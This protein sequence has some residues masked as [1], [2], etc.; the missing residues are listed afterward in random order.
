MPNNEENKYTVDDILREYDNA[1]EP[2]AE[3]TVLPEEDVIVYKPIELFE[4]NVNIE[5]IKEDIEEISESDE[6]I[7]EILEDEADDEIDISEEIL[8]VDRSEAENAD[9]VMNEEKTIEDIEVSDCTEPEKYFKE[10]EGN[11]LPT[12]RNKDLKAIRNNCT[13]ALSNK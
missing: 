13:F 10:L 9:I 7:E 4:E 11:K 3:K 8:E 6:A 12:H 5:D 1:S 2:E